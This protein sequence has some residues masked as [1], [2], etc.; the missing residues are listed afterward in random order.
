MEKEDSSSYVLL[1]ADKNIGIA[2]FTKDQVLKIYGQIN[3][4]LGYTR[5]DVTEGDSIK[6][7]IRARN[8]IIPVIPEGLKSYLTVNQVKRF[9]TKTG[10]LGILRP[11][12]KLHKMP[13]PRIFISILCDPAQSKP[14]RMTLLTM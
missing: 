10:T 6:E 8:D 7:F 13:T 11:L 3:A 9:H 2:L 14:L 4:E 12:P 5:L 1:E